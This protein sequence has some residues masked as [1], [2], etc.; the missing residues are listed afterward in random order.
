MLD[1]RSVLPKHIRDAR[2]K[3]HILAL[4]YPLGRRAGALLPLNHNGTSI[5]EEELC[6]QESLSGGLPR[7]PNRRSSQNSL[8]ANSANFACKELL[9]LSPTRSV[10]HGPQHLERRG[11]GA[12]SVLCFETCIEAQNSPRPSEETTF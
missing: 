3:S 12:Q 5:G 6:T 10:P 2:Y 11:S 8:Q 7:T 4:P 9:T 1:P